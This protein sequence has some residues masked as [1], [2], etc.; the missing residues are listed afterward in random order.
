MNAAALILSLILSSIWFDFAPT[1][2]FLTGA[3]IVLVSV[4]L[5]QS[6]QPSISSPTIRVFAVDAADL[7]DDV[8]I[9][10]EEDAPPLASK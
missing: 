8:V 9:E 3:A 10:D 4:Y 2:G 5:F 6:H 7:V 1:L